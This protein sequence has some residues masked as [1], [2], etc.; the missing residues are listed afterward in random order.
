[1]QKLFLF[2]LLFLAAG[3]EHADQKDKYSMHDD[4]YYIEDGRFYLESLKGQK[5]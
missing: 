1:M 4:F 2:I 5:H 3:C